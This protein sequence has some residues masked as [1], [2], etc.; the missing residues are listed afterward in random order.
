MPIT[1]NHAF[2]FAVEVFGSTDSHAED[3]TGA[4]LRAALLERINKLTDEEIVDACDAPYDT[5]EE[6]T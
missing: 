6:D 1:Y 2:S 5:M 3:V 4:Q